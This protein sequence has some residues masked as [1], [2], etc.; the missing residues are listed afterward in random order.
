MEASEV[1]FAMLTAAFDAGGDENTPFLTV[2]GFVSSVGDWEEFSALWRERLKKEGIEYSR[3]VEAAHFR[4][5]FQPWHDKPD[6][7]RWRQELLADLMDLVKAHAYRKFGCSIINKRF[8]SIGDDLRKHYR[9]RAYSLAGRTCEKQ[10]RDWASAERI[11]TPIEFVF[12]S[13]DEGHNELQVRLAADSGN[14]P[15]FRPKK[16][17]VLANG[18]V[19]RGFVP[20]QAA[21]WLAYE[22]NALAKFAEEN[23]NLTMADLRWPIQEFNRILGEPGIYTEEDTDR[24]EHMLRLSG[25]ID[26]WAKGF[27]A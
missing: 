25:K 16:D 11:K 6:R 2:A 19:Q 24:L 21:D 7:E 15:V 14:V 12:E 5:Q 17:T 8:Q 26:D 18:H 9:L 4:K 10:V 3:A 27:G 20:F 22:L 23:K 13:G 1:P